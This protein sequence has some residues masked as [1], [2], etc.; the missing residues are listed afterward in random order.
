MAGPV[1]TCLNNS[2]N[3]FHKS[4]AISISEWQRLSAQ[5]A[6]FFNVVAIASRSLTH[7]HTHTQCFTDSSE[8]CRLATLSSVDH[9]LLLYDLHVQRNSSVLKN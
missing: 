5:G 6:R 9:D 4:C 3:R 2:K 7:T 1:S 8:L